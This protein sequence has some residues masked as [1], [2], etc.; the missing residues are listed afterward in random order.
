MIKLGMCVAYDWLLLKQSLPPLYPHVDQIVLSLDKDRKT[1][2]GEHFQ[3]DQELFISFVREID[4]DSKIKVLE[5][6]FYHPSK[7]P[8]ENDNAQRTAMATALG[9]GGWHLQVDADEYFLDAVGFVQE[10]HRISSNP[11]QLKPINITCP[12]ISLIKKLDN[13]YLFVLPTNGKYE[14][15]PIATNVPEYTNA[16]RNGHFNH[17]APYYILHDTW[18]REPRQLQAKL[19]SWGHS[20]DFDVE[21]YFNLWLALDA[22]NYKYIRNFHPL[23]PELWPALGFSQASN[24]EE[25]MNQLPAILPAISKPWGQN[26]R[27]WSKL[28]SVLGA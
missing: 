14:T 20:I 12:W 22:H 24:A 15:T 16:R 26:S 11:E 2:S 7:S 3:F 8:I 18:S 17:L 10:L 13:G 21:S 28:K 5:E 6:Q 19:R 23:S 9:S 1:W 27:L 25:L 4:R